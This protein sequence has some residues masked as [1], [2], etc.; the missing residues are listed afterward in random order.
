MSTPMKIEGGR[1][2]SSSSPARKS[3]AAAASGFAPQ[4]ETTRDVAT[5]APTNAAASLDAILALQG[6]DL[7]TERRGRQV[8]RGRRALDVL[9]DL[10]R[11]LLLGHAPGSLRVELESLGTGSESTGDS[12]LDAILLEVD[13]RVAV[14]LA[15]LEMHARAA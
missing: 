9:S 12:E 15:K 14:E 4:T 5:A 6:E 2:V 13:T 7:E 10:E 11:A 1:N 3:G 8:R